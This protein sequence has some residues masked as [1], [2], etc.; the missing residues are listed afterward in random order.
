MKGNT[1]ET[2]IKQYTIKAL[3]YVSYSHVLPFYACRLCADT[4][5]CLKKSYSYNSKLEK[6]LITLDN[7]N[8]RIIIKKRVNIYLFN[9][10]H[11]LQIYIMIQRNISPER[12]ESSSF[13]TL[14]LFK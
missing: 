8:I 5:S 13:K 6:F 3:I 1:Y 10:I 2:Y 9:K 4:K 14:S 7:I 12:K 11:I